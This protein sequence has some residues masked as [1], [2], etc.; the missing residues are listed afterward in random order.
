MQSLFVIFASPTGVPIVV[1][2]V[3]EFVYNFKC[4]LPEGDVNTALD[5]DGGFFA[6]ETER[7]AAGLERFCFSAG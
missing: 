3:C 1:A 6:A 5:P 4:N 2:L 7:P